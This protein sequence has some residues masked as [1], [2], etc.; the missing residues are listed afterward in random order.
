[1][2]AI[3]FAALWTVARADTPLFPPEQYDTCSPNGIHCAHV[4][5][6]EGTTIYLIDDLGNRIVLWSMAGWFRDLYV[7][8]GGMDVVTGY[9]GL[10]LLATNYSSDWVMLTFWHKGMVV[11]E[12]QLKDMF[13]DLSVL[14]RTVSHYHWGSTRGF[15]KVGRFEVMTVDGRVLEYEPPS[16]KLVEER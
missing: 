10:N 5:P 16:G 13:K 3:C 12:V 4:D 6:Q 14:E 1:M 2:L 15:N 9:G 7:S 8:D 11:R